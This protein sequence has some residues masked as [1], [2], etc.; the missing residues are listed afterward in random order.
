MISLWDKLMAF[1]VLENGMV[2]MAIKL[3]DDYDLILVKMAE[4]H[5]CFIKL[6]HQSDNSLS[7]VWCQAII[8]TNDGL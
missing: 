5:V 3:F 1:F 4:W 2:N 6:D 8:G 7:L